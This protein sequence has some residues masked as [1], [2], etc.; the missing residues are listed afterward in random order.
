VAVRVGQDEEAGLDGGR[1]CRVKEEA[2]VGEQ[3]TEE[4][5]TAGD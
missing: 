1:G 4:A 3:T 5:A 2:L